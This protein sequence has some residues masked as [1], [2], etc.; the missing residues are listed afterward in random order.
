MTTKAKHCDNNSKQTI[1][2][3]NFQENEQLNTKHIQKQLF[4]HVEI[5][6]YAAL[7]DRHIFVGRDYVN[8]KH[9]W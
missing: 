3:W 7:C 9:E 5:S 4:L 8:Y 6:G 2:T 1:E